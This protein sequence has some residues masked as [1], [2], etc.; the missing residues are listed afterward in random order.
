[1][2]EKKA[3]EQERNWIQGKGTPLENPLGDDIDLNAEKQG[4]IEG[5]IPR[6]MGGPGAGHIL[7]SPDFILGAMRSDQKVFSESNE[8]R[9]QT[10]IREARELSVAPN[11]PV[12]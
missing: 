6:E 3:G 4:N 9:N 11:P 12:F 2:E 10:G 5:N 1:M 8:A 7:Q